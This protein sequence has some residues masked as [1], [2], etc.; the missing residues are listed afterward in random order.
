L[1]N[2]ALPYLSANP[3][4]A[5]VAEG[6]GMRA[7]DLVQEATKNLQNFPVDMLTPCRELTLVHAVSKPLQPPAITLLC[8]NRQIGETSAG[9]RVSVE[10][11]RKSTGKVDIKATWE[12]WI[13]DPNMDSLVKTPG[14]AQIGTIDVPEEPDTDESPDSRA[15]IRHS[16]ET[17]PAVYAFRQAFADTIHRHVTY[18]PVATSRFQRFFKNQKDTKRFQLPGSGTDQQSV[19]ILSTRRPPPPDIAYVVPLYDWKPKKKDKR[20]FTSTRCGG[21]LRIY[22]RRPWYLS[23]EN[24]KIGIVLWGEEQTQQNVAPVTP[25]DS[26]VQLSSAKFAGDQGEPL[27][28]H[29]VTRWGADPEWSDLVPTLA[30]LSAMFARESFQEDGLTQECGVP[31]HGLSLEEI[32]PELSK[33][34]SVGHPVTIPTNPAPVVTLPLPQP[35]R[36][37]VSVVTYVPRY[38]SQKQLWY[39]DVFLSEVPAYSCFIRLAVIRYQPY[40]LRH[41]EC[42]HVSLAAFAQL[43]ANRSVTVS[44]STTKH[45]IEVEVRGNCPGDSAL[46]LVDSKKRNEFDLIVEHARHDIDGPLHWQEEAGVTA[47]VVEKCSDTDHTLLCKKTVTFQQPRGKKRLVVKEY[48][49]KNSDGD[50]S[51]AAGGQPVRRLVFADVLS[52]P[53]F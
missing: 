10:A 32:E 36:Y 41:A 25:A 13:D 9:L 12:E 8:A 19:H 50:Q 51:S 21:G 29:Y 7:A 15:P 1:L 23:G 37:P 27:L 48:E 30:P 11:D 20:S 26:C 28:R 24:E 34:R 2:H 47:C 42:S 6:S 14:N 38:D 22:L 49:W 31:V 18:F 46:S 40:S 45:S 39:C 17:D 44:R 16:T 5:A 35:T 3:Q 4:L 53:D 43:P 33:A 52:L